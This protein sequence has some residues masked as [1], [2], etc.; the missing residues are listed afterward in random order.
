MKKAF[1]IL[2]NLYG[3]LLGW[4]FLEPLHHAIINLSLHALG[5]GNVYRDSWTGE[6]WF[7]KKV[8]TP[9]NPKLVFDIGANIGLYSELLLKY[10]DA[11][12]HAF[13]PNPS[14]F[15][16]LKL[17]ESRVVKINCALGSEEGVATLFYRGDCDVKASLDK[18]TTQ[19]SSVEVMVRRLDVYVKEHELS[20]IDFIKIDTEGF[21]KEVLQGMGT[22]RPAYIQFEFN[23]NHLYRS[24]TFYDLA[25]LLPDYTFYRLIPNGWIKISPQKYLNNIF[26]F[27]TSLQ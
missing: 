18:N 8:L 16:R 26:M 24:C 5:Y 4:S 11:K 22:I 3:K 21:E 2:E 6:E 20:N 25:E 17:L 13:E 14:S 12:I 23:I 7:I 1:W 19:D 27:Q 9:Q 15:E 10:T